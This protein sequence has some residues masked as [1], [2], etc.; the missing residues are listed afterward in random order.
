MLFLI[1]LCSNLVWIVQITQ[2]VCQIFIFVEE[3]KYWEYL[4][5]CLERLVG[6]LK[7][8]TMYASCHVQKKIQKTKK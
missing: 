3:V 1:Q 4:F 6:Q 2:I 7:I 5:I 8:D